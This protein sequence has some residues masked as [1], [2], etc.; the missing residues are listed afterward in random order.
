[1]DFSTTCAV[2]YWRRKML[3]VPKLVSCFLIMVFFLLVGCNVFGQ[4]PSPIALNVMPITLMCNNYQRVI[5]RVL[6]HID[7]HKD[8]RYLHFAYASDVGESGSSLYELNGEKAPLSYTRYIQ[9]NCQYY[10]FTACVLRT[11]GK[12]FCS[13]MEVHPP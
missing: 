2:T 6:I 5:V 4:K 1:M 7:P 3:D 10:L 9:V 11:Q 12:K 13:K 8:N